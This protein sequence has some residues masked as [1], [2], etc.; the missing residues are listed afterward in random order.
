MSSSKPVNSKL[1]EVS[2]FGLRHEA[3]QSKRSKLKL[4]LL[5]KQNKTVVLC[6]IKLQSSE[7]KVLLIA[8]N[9]P[10]RLKRAT[11]QFPPEARCVRASQ[12]KLDYTITL[13]PPIPLHR[14]SVRKYMTS[15]WTCLS[16]ECHHTPA[17]TGKPP[18]GPTIIMSIRLP[19][20]VRPPRHAAAPP[21]HLPS[22]NLR[23][24]DSSGE[25]QPAS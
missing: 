8:H 2:R 6:V 19:F 13:L 10:R 18:A 25:A 12:I 22:F 23:L 11:F 14:K 16:W 5:K 7:D 9:D 1:D 4:N 20:R 24:S 3:L 17:Q 21:S 15:W